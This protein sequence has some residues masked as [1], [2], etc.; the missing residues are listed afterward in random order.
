MRGDE[1]I[2]YSRYRQRFLILLVKSLRSSGISALTLAAFCK[3]L[4]R[5]AITSSPATALFVIPLITELIT[6]HSSLYAMIQVEDHED[7]YDV[8]AVRK[9]LP[10]VDKDEIATVKQKQVNDLIDEEDEESE[11]NS[12]NES[13]SEEEKEIEKEVAG[14]V[15]DNKPIAVRSTTVLSSDILKKTLKRMQEKRERNEKSPELPAKQPKLD[16]HFE[17]MNCVESIME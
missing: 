1:W 3:R 17:S 14:E 9:M 6:Y 8:V 11:S 16:Y 10:G 4:C 2:L 12:E 15:E 7:V 5:I 13:D